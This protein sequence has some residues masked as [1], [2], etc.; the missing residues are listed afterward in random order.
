MFLV[1]FK[2]AYFQIL[3]LIFRSH[4]RGKFASLSASAIL[5]LLR[6]SPVFILVSN[7]VHRRGVQLLYLEKLVNCLG[8]NSSAA[9][10]S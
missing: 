9:A 1:S 10:T 4:S 8:V 2:G 5:Q 3:G 7:R 6:S